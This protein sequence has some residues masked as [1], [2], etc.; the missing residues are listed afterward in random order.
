VFKICEHT[1]NFMWTYSQ[2]YVN[3]QPTLCEHTTNFMWTYSQLYVNIQPTL[4]EHTAN[5]MWTYSQLYVNMQPTLCEHAAN[6]MW[7][8]S[9]LYVNIQPT[10]C[11]FVPCIVLQL[12][13]VN[14]QNALLKLMF[15]SSC[16]LH[17]SNILCSSSGRL[18]CVFSLIWHVFHE[19]MQAV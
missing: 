9:Q 2:L 1:A 11:F 10:L 16:L 15:N 18:C 3:I 14:Q 7:T 4:C 17:V 8:C 12:C 5:F 6:F 19:F 13:N